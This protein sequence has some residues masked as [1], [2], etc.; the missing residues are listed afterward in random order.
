MSVGPF[1]GRLLGQPLPYVVGYLA[2]ANM[3]A[4]LG[5][6]CL[7]YAVAIAAT[8][9]YGIE[10]IG[11]SDLAQVVQS[12]P[13]MNLDTRLFLLSM[14]ELEGKGSLAELAEQARS[15]LSLAVP[16]ALR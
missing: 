5:A 14:L 16:E 11:A 3:A 9:T 1:R 7:P 10:A 2:M 6:Y 4:R 15:R 8:I 12:E 13:R